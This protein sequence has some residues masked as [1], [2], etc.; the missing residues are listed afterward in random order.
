M[1]G[2]NLS[3]PYDS[4]IFNYTWKNTPDLILTTMLESGAVVQDSEIARMISNGSNFF[5]VP[6]YDLLGGTEQVSIRCTTSS[7]YRFNTLI[8]TNTCYVSCM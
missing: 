3:F 2:T 7:N 1:A 4:E 8:C 5:T 6:Y